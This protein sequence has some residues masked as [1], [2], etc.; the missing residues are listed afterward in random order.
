MLFPM[1][2]RPD[3]EAVLISGLITKACGAQDTSASNTGASAANLLKNE[4]FSIICLSFDRLG[5]E[6]ILVG[7]CDLHIN[8]LAEKL[9]RGNISE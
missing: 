1:R 6:I 4:V 7:A 3:L 9:G 5:D 2:F 8:K